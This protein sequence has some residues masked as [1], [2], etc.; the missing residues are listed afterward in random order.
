MIR[1]MTG[2]GMVQK[3]ISLGRVTAEARSHNHRYLDISL[4]LPKKLYPFETRIKEMVRAHFFVGVR[5]SL[6]R[7]RWREMLFPFGR[8]YRRFC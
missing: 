4:R 1:S 8:S 3:V 7:R 2:Y 6:R 5:M